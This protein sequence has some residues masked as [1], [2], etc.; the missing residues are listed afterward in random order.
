[1]TASA[2]RHGSDVEDDIIDGN[3][4]G[5]G[6]V[7]GGLVTF[8][9]SS[10]VLELVWLPWSRPRRPRQLLNTCPQQSDQNAFILAIMLMTK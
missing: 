2:S 8:K 3:G 4:Q 5:V 9:V 7:E 10:G 6:D 1:M